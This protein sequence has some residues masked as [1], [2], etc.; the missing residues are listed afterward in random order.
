MCCA[1]QRESNYIFR[2]FVFAG[3]KTCAKHRPSNLPASRSLSRV[4][5][6][7]KRASTLAAGCLML[8]WDAPVP[9][10]VA[11]RVT[12]PRDLVSANTYAK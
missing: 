3:D 7:S 5:E 2:I 9:L 11:I 8:V 6:E 4:Y 12:D 10:M 1:S